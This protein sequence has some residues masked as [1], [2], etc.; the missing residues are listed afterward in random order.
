MHRPCSLLKRRFCF[1]TKVR[2]AD[3]A[4]LEHIQVWFRL[5]LCCVLRDDR[6]R[7]TNRFLRRRRWDIHLGHWVCRKAQRQFL[8]LSIIK[9]RFRSFMRIFKTRSAKCVIERVPRH[10]RMNMSVVNWQTIQPRTCSVAV[11]GRLP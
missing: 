11:F 1:S 6:Y 9:G 8:S 3:E 2:F 4:P 5:H 7:R 10:I